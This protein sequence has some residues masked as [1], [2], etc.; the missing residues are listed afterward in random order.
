MTISYFTVQPRLPTEWQKSKNRGFLDEGREIPFSFYD[1]VMASVF[2]P[3]DSTDDY[4]MLVLERLW[5]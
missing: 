4:M 2:T 5:I 1:F 3:A